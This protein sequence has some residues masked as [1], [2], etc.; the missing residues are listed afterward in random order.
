[1]YKR[2]EGPQ[3]TL[4][5]VPGESLTSS[6][7]AWSG[8]WCAGPL[9]QGQHEGRRQDGNG[10]VQGDRDRQSVSVRTDV[11]FGGGSQ[12]A[13]EEDAHDGHADRSADLLTGGEHSGGQA[14]FRRGDPGQHSVEEGGDEQEVGLIGDPGAWPAAERNLIWRVLTDP[15]M[16]LLMVDWL[17]QAQDLLAQF[18]ADVGENPGD[19]Q[20][21]SLTKALHQVSPEFRGWWDRYDIAAF[22]SSRR[23]FN[24]PR[25][26]LLNLD[27]A[28]LAALDAP[29]IKLFT[30]L[31]ADAATAL[32]LP[33][34]IV[35][36][37]S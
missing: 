22:S 37:P 28:K 11:E 6:S 7:N 15:Q 4:I 9:R 14:D 3:P 2:R 19:P 34:L 26:G 16:R 27:Y 21:Q 32:K 25:L 20:L 36:D 29:G 31:P 1:M 24:H 30:C 17:A 18:R 10:R 5:H 35:V 23:Q 33:Q 12:S 13:V 8:S